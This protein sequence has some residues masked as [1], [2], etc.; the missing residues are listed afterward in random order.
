M[1]NQVAI[2][3]REDIVKA[4]DRECLSAPGNSHI[5]IGTHK[6]GK[7]YLL[8]H[9][10]SRPTSG[11]ESLFCKVDLDILDVFARGR[12]LSDDVFLRFFLSQLLGQINDWIDEQSKEKD[13]WQ[14]DIRQNEEA[15]KVLSISNNPLLHDAVRDTKNAISA[16]KEKQEELGVLI[17]VSGKIQVLIN[18]AQELM[19]YML[20][21]IIDILHDKN[22]RIILIID[23]FNLL[24]K[25]KGLGPD[26][27]QFLRGMNNQGKIIVLASSIVH[28]MDASLH[29][30]VDEHDRR[31]YFNYFG[32]QVLDPFTKQEAADF[33]CWLHGGDC[34]LAP[35][36]K[37]YLQ[38]LG[39]GSPFFLELARD[40]YLQYGRPKLDAE[41]REFEQILASALIGPF[42]QIWER[43]NQEDRTTLRKLAAGEE[44]E[45]SC[46]FNLGKEGYLTKHQ[47]GFKIFSTLFSDFIKQQSKSSQSEP[48]TSPPYKSASGE[49]V[50]VG[51]PPTATVQVFADIPFEVLPTALYIADLKYAD[52]L[53]FKIVNHTET[54]WDVYLSCQI[55]DYSQKTEQM[56]S[57][58]PKTEHYETLPVTFHP[59][60]I[61]IL[62]NE[63]ARTQITCRAELDMGS[64][65]KVIYNI[66]KRVLLLPV[67]NFI[68]TR[69]N[70]NEKTWIDF[71][72]LITAW[73]KPRGE[74]LWEIIQRA[75]EFEPRI[76]RPAPE[77]EAGRPL[78]QAQ[79][80]GIYRALQERKLN[81]HNQVLVYHQ[82][83]TDYV[84]RVQFPEDTLESNVANCL[85]GVVLFASLL[86]TCDLEPAI[87]LMRGHALVGWK[88]IRGSQVE[89]DFLETTL[90]S[91]ATFQ[92]ACEE[93][94]KKFAEVKDFCRLGEGTPFTFDPEA[95][96]IILDVHEIWRRR[97]ILP[98]YG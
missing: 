82:E 66:P 4:I 60:K 28:P 40:R 6:V 23:E 35:D 13:S 33:L 26:L 3:D 2:F 90:V 88:T 74:R 18:Q 24:I 8:N 65:R 83:E 96:A 57:V 64:H 36:E 89:W 51:G 84:Q 30:E 85:D 67:N 53:T 42:S 81:Y 39:G 75:R 38:D 20:V 31:S 41:R 69:F 19:S 97:R 10:S 7:T 59:E 48:I 92:Q 54:T 14:A 47:T 61:A 68:F 9:I 93:G 12:A 63:G 70:P 44:I 78:I 49:T 91:T 21:D 32:I 1:M 80:E 94:R 22:K 79:V 43:C 27:F 87:L 76:G 62:R 11:R 55:V 46:C 52:L 29:S 34:P 58:P 73:V 72:W 37:Q 17:D 45:P 15:L 77:G 95:F 25:E 56:V 71:T 16:L 86:S 50:R 98:L 5:I